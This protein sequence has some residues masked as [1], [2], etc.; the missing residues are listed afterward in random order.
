MAKPTFFKKTLS[1]P[2]RVNNRSSL[3]RWV[4]SE[5]PGRDPFDSAL[6]QTAKLACV[7]EMDVGAL[8]GMGVCVLCLRETYKEHDVDMKPIDLPRD[9]ATILR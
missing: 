5:T 8:L 6:G 1:R 4:V 3:A 7:L 9:M 2:S